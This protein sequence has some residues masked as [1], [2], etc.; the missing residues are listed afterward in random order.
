MYFGKGIG[1]A[2]RC[3]NVERGLAVNPFGAQPKKNQKKKESFLVEKQNN[4]KRPV[5]RKIFHIE[6]KKGGWK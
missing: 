2:G 3:F 1:A 5:S 4:L 6:A